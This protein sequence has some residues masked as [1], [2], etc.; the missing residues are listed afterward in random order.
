[1]TELIKIGTTYEAE[2]SSGGYSPSRLVSKVG[3]LADI[4]A[5]PAGISIYILGSEKELAGGYR[6]TD[7]DDC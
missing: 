2:L 4:E 3:W 1:M 7:D 6:K 5:L